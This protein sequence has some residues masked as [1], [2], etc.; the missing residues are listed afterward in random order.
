MVDAATAQAN[1]ITDLAWVNILMGNATTNFVQSPLAYDPSLPLD[2]TNPIPPT[3][4]YDSVDCDTPMRLEGIPLGGVSLARDSKKWSKLTGRFNI[5]WTPNDQTL[6][7]LSYTTGYRSGG[8]G[9]GISDART[10][11]PTKY[12]IFL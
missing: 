7:Y 11:T 4:A 12:A 9:L 1:G 5:D 8:F 10:A 6:V 3:C 2:P